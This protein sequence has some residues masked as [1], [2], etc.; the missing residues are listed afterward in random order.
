MPGSNI[1]I[2]PETEQVLRDLAAKEGAA[3][4]EILG[5][6][7]ELYRRQRFLDELNAAYSTLKGDPAAWREEQ[8]ERE[9]WDQTLGDGLDRE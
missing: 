3:I 9:A 4:E 7:I 2:N 5:R 6:A 8:A 1:A